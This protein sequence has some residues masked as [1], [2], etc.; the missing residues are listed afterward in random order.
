MNTDTTTTTAVLT[1][2]RRAVGQAA[3][4]GGADAGLPQVLAAARA[5]RRHRL[6]AYGSAAGAGLAACAV[7][8]LAL[9]GPGAGPQVDPGTAAAG[10][11]TVRTTGA[12]GTSV[13]LAAWSV[14][15]S[16]DGSVTVTLRELTDAAQLKQALAANGVPALLHFGD[17]LCSAD[18]APQRGPIGIAQIRAAGGHLTFTMTFKVSLWPAGSELYVAN[19]PLG[20]QMAVIPQ[21]HYQGCA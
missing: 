6:T 7:L 19:S 21:G 15:A 18:R 10:A 13:R 12:A 4:P 1:A 8:T 11:G 16:R 5:R 3:P 20:P 14:Q 9:S 17:G 2:V